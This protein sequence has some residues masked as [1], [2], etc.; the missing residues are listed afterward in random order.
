[1]PKTERA[2]LRSRPAAESS[3]RRRVAPGSSPSSVAPLPDPATV[4]RREG[5]GARCPPMPDHHTPA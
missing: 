1:M 2:E 5:L 4:S 3:G